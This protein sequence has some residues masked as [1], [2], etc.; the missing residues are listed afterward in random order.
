MNNLWL[1]L[2]QPVLLLDFCI[3]NLYFL[4]AQLAHFDTCLI[5]LFVIITFFDPILSEG[6]LQPK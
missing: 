1:I 2:S 4:A 5:T 6:F 3:K